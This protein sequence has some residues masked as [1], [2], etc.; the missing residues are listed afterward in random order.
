V[1][2]ARRAPSSGPL[3]P[4]IAHLYPPHSPRHSASRVPAEG[5][6]EE[7]LRELR[8]REAKMLKLKQ[9]QSKVI[10]SA[11]TENAGR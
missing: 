11:R 4:N 10:R 2:P 5:S 9:E 1:A 3:S 6:Q 8:A 7:V